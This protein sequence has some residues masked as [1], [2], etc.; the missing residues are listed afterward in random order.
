MSDQYMPQRVFAYNSTV[1]LVV[2]TPFFI[3]RTEI[4]RQ[5]AGYKNLFDI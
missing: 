3:G 1:K 2:M 5:I 4:L